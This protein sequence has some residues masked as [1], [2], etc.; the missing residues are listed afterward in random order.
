MFCRN[1]GNELANNAVMCP[2]CGGPTPNTHVPNYLVQAILTTLFCCLPFG[3]VAIVYAAQVNGKL[4]AGD[5]NGAVQASRNA[6]T[7]SWVSFGAGLVF[8]VLYVLVAIAA[9]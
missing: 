9:G 4:V 7:W 8:T 6:A 1:C 3:I 2:R 5:Y